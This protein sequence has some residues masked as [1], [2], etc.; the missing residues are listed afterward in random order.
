M[1]NSKVPVANLFFTLSK[2]MILNFSYFLYSIDFETLLCISF[3]FFRS[4][5]HGQRI[6]SIEALHQK[7]EYDY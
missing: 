4:S 2:F 1:E 5:V 3:I 6:H 7:G